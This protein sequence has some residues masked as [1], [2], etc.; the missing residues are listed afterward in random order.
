MKKLEYE[1]VFI[2]GGTNRT[3][4]VLNEYG[5]KGWELVGANWVW[6]YFK[7]EMQESSK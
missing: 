7:R 4:R 3:T 5:Q 6:F 2:W 1:C